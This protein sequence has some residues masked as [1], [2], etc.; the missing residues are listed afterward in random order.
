MTERTNDLF[1]SGAAWL[2]ADFH[3]HTKADREFC[4]SGEESYYINNY[5][6]SL[7]QAGIKIGVITNHNKFDKD[8]FK[9]LNKVARNRNIFLLPGVE[10]SV[11]DGSNGVHVLIIFSEQWLER[12]DDYI[13]PFISSMFTGRIPQ[14][15][16]NKNG[17]SDK[18]ILQTVEELN[19]IGRDYILIFAHVEESKGLWNGTEG[20]KFLEWNEDR[21]KVVKER[22]LGF[23]KVRTH[24]KPDC[25]CRM[26]VQ[27][28]LKNAYP[29]EVE[30]SDP[31]KLNEIGRG[32]SCFLK[33]G[34]FT[35]D[36]V[37]FALADYASRVAKQVPEYQHSHIKSI[38]F[39]GGIF[40]GK[41]IH[42]SP[43]LN[44]L[45]GIRGSG[46]SAVLEVLRYVLDIPFGEKA[47]DRKYKET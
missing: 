8:E 42:F 37:K 11:N 17:L 43:E 4:F 32:E 40:A 1:Q 24:D 45:I 46:K 35:F 13:N 21:Y 18:N 25:I 22:T 15:Y 47:G 39:E 30:G 27:K 26:N 41:T 29:A 16:Q 44:T 33:I 36:A 12:G 3:L 10:L 23:Q 31:K 7:E 20:G 34:A 19:K 38:S 9:N 6:N 2:R 5:I 28:W 14:Q